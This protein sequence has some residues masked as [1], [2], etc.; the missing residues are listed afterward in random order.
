M[1][2]AQTL[3]CSSPPSDYSRCSNYLPDTAEEEEALLESAPEVSPRLDAGSGVKGPRRD[4]PVGVFEILRLPVYRPAIVAV[5]GVMLAQQ[6]CGINSIIMY[7]VDL[8]SELLPTTSALLT[9]VV[10]GINLV[11]T[12]LCAPLADRLGRKACLLLSIAGMGTNALLLAI[13]IFFAIR[14][15]SAL[16]VLLFV[17]SFAVGLGPVPFILASE[18]VGTEAVGATQSWALVANWTATFLVAQFFPIL[19]TA[20]GRGRVYYLFA[21]LA[22]CFFAFVLWWVPETKGKKDA[23]EV[24]GRER[25][26]D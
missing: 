12:L 7:S 3:V 18:L 10:S 17:A 24:W 13:S 25:R 11:T 8:L 4:R 21:A 22:A 26:V 2:S 15:L 16:A 5:V 9:V 23:D 14:V 19:N 20:L 6:L 1:T